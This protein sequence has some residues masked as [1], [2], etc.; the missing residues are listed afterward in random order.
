MAL[1]LGRSASTI[2]DQIKRHS[3]MGLGYLASVAQTQADGSRRLSGRLSR[4]ALGG[5]LF[6]GRDG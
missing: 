3:D 5:P 1:A 6:A 4:L 2:S